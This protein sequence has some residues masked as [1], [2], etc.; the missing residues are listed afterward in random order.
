MQHEYRYAVLPLDTP[1]DD[2]RWSEY[3]D[4]F[5]AGLLDTWATEAGLA[6]YREHRRANGA[7]LGYVAVEGQTTHTMAAAFSC[8]VGSVNAGSG[9]VPVLIIN[10]IAVR[11]EHR[12]KGLLREMM[13]QHLDAARADGV[14]LAT[15][16]ASEGTI[17]GRFG[18]GVAL[19]RHSIN[20]DTR[21]FAFRP[22]VPVA[23]GRVEWVKPSEVRPH[24]E[25]IAQRF[26][27]S[28]RG[29]LMPQHAH[30]LIDGGAWDPA[31]R[32]PSTGLRGLV[33]FDSDG[34]PDGYA[35]F[36]HKGWDSTPVTAAINRVVAG[37]PAVKRA[38][39]R[40]LASMDLVERL[41]YPLSHPNDPLWLALVD[42]WAIEV[43][44]A[45]DFNWL[46]ILDLPAAVSQ[47]RFDVDGSMVIAVT[48]PMGY[49]EGTWRI[50]VEYGAAGDDH[51][52][53]TGRDGRHRC[54]GDAVVR[55]PNGGRPHRRR[56]HHRPPPRSA[57]P[58]RHRRPPVEHLVDLVTR[59]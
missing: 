54:L 14:A 22:E 42:P 37:D 11:P 29:S 9:G 52:L 3:V 46:R 49:C 6:I 56:P 39:W 16:S 5:R 25:Q 13:R 50:E 59:R 10:T 41:T 43:K 19:R 4:I 21:R 27:A 48:D 26:Q 7:T 15:L 34:N 20:V 58:L 18:F 44:E 40:A 32:G 12:R 45:G 23:G 53:R 2:P 31:A 28:H 47:R 17:Y 55:R 36:Q 38:L 57:S 35:V 51:R 33:H 24:L 30:H 1:D 8:A